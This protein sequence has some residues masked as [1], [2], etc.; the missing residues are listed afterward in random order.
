MTTEKDQ[1]A[2][3][4]KAQLME[5]AGW[6]AD[7]I[8]ADRKRALDYYFQRPRGD[9]V[10]GRSN[11]VSGD[12]S[13]MTEANLAQMMEAFTSDEIIEFEPEGEADEAQAALESHTCVRFVMQ[14]NPGFLVLSETIKDILNLRNGVIKCWVDRNQV[15]ERKTIENATAEVIA[16]LE[17]QPGVRVELLS[18]TQAEGQPEGVGTVELRCHYDLRKFRVESIDLANFY[19][20][21]D[22][23][24][25]DL[26]EVPFCAERHIEPRSELYRRGFPRKKVANLKPITSD[27]KID[28]TARS[29]RNAMP[30][31][32]A[33]DKSQEL[34]EWYEIY[35]LVDSG[36]GTS[37]R[38]RYAL[39]G[40]NLGSVLEDQPVTL[41]PY[42]AGTAI[43]N[44]HRFTGISLFDKLRQTQDLNTGLTRALMD[45]VNTVIKSR[46]AY[47]DG[48]VN[49]DDLSDGRPNGN[50]RVR[51]SVQDVRQA[52][53]PF[54]T[55][56]LSGGILQNLEHQRNVR[57]E[58]GGA[59]LEM[60]SG[61]MQLASER[62]GSEGVDRAFSV[63]EQL[64]SLYTKNVAS[65]LIR[66][67]FLLAH[68]TLREN[69]NEPIN[70]KINGKWQEP[71]PAA[72]PERARLN[73]KPGMSPGERARRS[74]ALQFVLSSQMDLAKE[75]MDDILVNMQ[76]FHRAF[77]DWGR[78]NELPSP[79]QYFLDPESESS[80]QALQQKQKAE[81]ESQ[82]QQRRLME[83]AV[84]LEQLRTSLDKYKHDTEMQFKYWAD[85]LKSEIEEMKVV[86]RATAD[87]LAAQQRGDD[88]AG[89]SNGASAANGSG[90]AESSDAD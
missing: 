29:V 1:L 12:L 44:P 17:A 61:Q 11:V 26:Q 42:A 3:R 63:M 49:V 45:N 15:S 33:I 85:V 28:S 36:D 5:C 14:D 58:M 52:L 60:A 70:V 55:T 38:R 69:Y 68:A 79:E 71:I 23:H 89:K 57:S 83:T 62:V 39:A 35:A 78:T 53:M 10:R 84:G 6:D 90:N 56:D 2:S 80:Q 72:W 24:K 86:G 16:S 46:L 87:L 47:L 9:E 27:Y 50:I 31:H 32:R 65:S 37:E 22:W 13:A 19:Y 21:K 75:G 20:P 43:V 74:N 41:V 82:A 73:V 40:L 77:M 34:I 51:A 8:A 30:N 67:L 76:G 25:L 48:K 54:T 4:L 81:Q 59:A 64:A 88:G 66:S 18:F 7:Q